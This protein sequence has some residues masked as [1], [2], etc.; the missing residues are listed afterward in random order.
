MTHTKART[1]VAGAVTALTAVL[2]ATPAFAVNITRSSDNPAYDVI[3]VNGNAAPG[4][5]TG[6]FQ[7]NGSTRTEIN[8]G[9][10]ELFGGSPVTIGDLAALSFWTNQAPQSTP[11]NWYVN[12]YTLKDDLNDDGFYG[13]RLNFE[14]IYADNRNEQDN[15]WT[16]WSTDGTENRLRVFDANRGDSG[17]V[18]GTHTDPFLSDLTSGPVNWSDYSSAYEDAL[19]DYRDEEISYIS[20]ATGSGWAD[21]FSGLIDGFGIDWRDG[22]GGLNS[23]SINLEA[24]G[25][26]PVGVPEPSTWVFALLVFLG[27]GYAAT[28]RRDH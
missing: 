24:A 23:S 18:F 17:P 14:P 3:G 22:N 11:V 12:V 8:I 25:G 6:S 19:V 26:A 20:I 28:K 15:V 16:Q 27:L 9:A 10:N 7:A 1:L 21:G 13:R 2:M 4:F 5:A